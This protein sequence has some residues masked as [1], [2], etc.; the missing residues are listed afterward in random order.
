MRIEATPVQVIEAP[1]VDADE[2]GAII[3]AAGALAGAI[4]AAVCD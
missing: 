1:D 4:V 3:A 2:W